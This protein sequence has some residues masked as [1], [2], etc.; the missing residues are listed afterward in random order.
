MLMN[1][2]HALT[3]WPTVEFDAP[4][5]QVTEV[6]KNAGGEIPVR[7]ESP[8]MPGIQVSLDAGEGRLF[9]MPPR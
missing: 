9:L 1:Y 5:E 3:A 4:A 2:R 8:E 7:D 6:D